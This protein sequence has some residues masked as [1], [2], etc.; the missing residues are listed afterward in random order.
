MSHEGNAKI[1]WKT[2]IFWVK[3]YRLQTFIWRR[4]QAL[5]AKGQ[6]LLKN[7]V[8]PLTF[9]IWSHVWRDLE[10]CLFIIKTERYNITHMT[11]LFAPSN[12]AK[13]NRP[14]EC[15]AILFFKIPLA[16]ANQF[17]Y[18]CLHITKEQG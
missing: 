1:R 15:D 4:L 2:R 14:K 11:F 10:R 8:Q 12:F 5:H 6:Q 17:D 9:P 3:K 7:L 16:L 18:V 13:C